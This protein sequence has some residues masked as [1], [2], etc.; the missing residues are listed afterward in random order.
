M[1]KRNNETQRNSQDLEVTIKK[2][3]EQTFD[4]NYE[5]GDCLLSEYGSEPAIKCVSEDQD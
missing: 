4:S 2:D 3:H 1:V 5:V